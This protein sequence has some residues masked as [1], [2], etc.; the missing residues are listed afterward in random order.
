MLS[1]LKK[2][3]YFHATEQPFFFYRREARLLKTGFLRQVRGVENT[4]EKFMTCFTKMV[5]LWDFLE[6][7]EFH[8]RTY[9]PNTRVNFQQIFAKDS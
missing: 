1:K 3:R 4:K 9:H 7:V 2:G 6:V 5:R 8:S